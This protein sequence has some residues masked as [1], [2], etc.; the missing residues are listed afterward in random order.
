MRRILMMIDNKEIIDL[1]NKGSV[2]T[3]SDL[4]II[5]QYCYDKPYE[6]ALIALMIALMISLMISLMIALIININININ[7]KEVRGMRGIARK[8][9]GSL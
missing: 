3:D 9:W 2:L 6:F 5:M 4:A 1:L 8:K 7:K